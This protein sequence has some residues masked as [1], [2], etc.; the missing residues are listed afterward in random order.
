[1]PQY[2]GLCMSVKL[3]IKHLLCIGAVVLRKGYYTAFL[4]TVKQCSGHCS[5]PQVTAC[6]YQPKKIGGDTLTVERNII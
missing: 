1:M 6:L 4:A 3:H 5:S 2:A